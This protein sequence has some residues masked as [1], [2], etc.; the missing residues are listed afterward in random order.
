MVEHQ[1]IVSNTPL[2]LCTTKKFV[3]YVLKG[4]LRSILVEIRY[5]LRKWASRKATRPRIRRPPPTGSGLESTD[6]GSDACPGALENQIYL[7]MPH[8]CFPFAPQP[9]A[10]SNR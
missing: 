1:L 3:I 2:S 8:L 6:G 9:A 10:V 4:C 7:L 5:D